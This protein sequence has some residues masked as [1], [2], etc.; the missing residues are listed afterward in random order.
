MPGSDAVALGEGASQARL[1]LMIL[2]VE[3]LPRSEAFYRAVFGWTARV[4][5]PVYV[6]FALPDG[7]GLG[8]YQREAFARNTGELPG[9]REAGAITGTELYLHCDDLDAA[10][11]RIEAAGGRT[12][13]P[14]A[15]RPWGD[16]ASYHADPDGNVLVLARPQ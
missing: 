12:L 3:S 4:R 5:V 6:E 16:L 11:G 2:A 15:P 13:S 9:P 8:L 14:C 1:I 7:R 10:I